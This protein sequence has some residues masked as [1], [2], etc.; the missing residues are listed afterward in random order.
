MIDLTYL[1]N[2][3]FNI[4]VS[5]SDGITGYD[6]D[7]AIRY[8]LA[9]WF[10]FFSSLM[11]GR[12]IINNGPNF[13]TSLFLIG[14]IFGL[15]RNGFMF[16]LDYGT[17]RGIFAFPSVLS[18]TLPIDH[19]FQM[20]S[21]LSMN[22]AILFLAKPPTTYIK[23]YHFS[24]VLPFIIYL[25]IAVVGKDFFENSPG[26]FCYGDFIYHSIMLV[27]C[28][29]ASIPAYINRKLI[30]ASLMGFLLFIITSQIYS[31][32]NVFTKM[33]YANI[34]VPY[35]NA[36]LM[37]ATPFIL[38]YVQSIPLRPYIPIR[39]TEDKL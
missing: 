31:L 2:E 4:M 25:I 30:P 28:V 26:C 39:I 23:Y 29:T 17:Y 22:Y 18:D 16:I 15:C 24:Y 8:L 32:I 7:N 11:L 21:L 33:H 34:L 3:V 6:H 12:R 36:Y 27:M 13:P 10:F 38:Y 19:T 37:W 1:C 9:F 14:C 35:Q 5:F 20:L